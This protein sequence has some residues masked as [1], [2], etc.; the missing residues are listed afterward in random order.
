MHTKGFYLKGEKIMFFNKKENK[1]SILSCCKYPT[2]FG[3]KNEKPHIPHILAVDLAK[4]TPS[5]SDNEYIW[6]D[7]YKGT[8]PEMNCMNDFH[9]ELD[10]IYTI[11]DEKELTVCGHGFN[12]CLKLSDVFMYKP[13][14]FSDSNRYFK[15]SASVLKKDFEHYGYCS[16]DYN[17]TNKLVAKSIVLKEEVPIEEIY[18]NFNLVCDSTAIVN[19]YIKSFLISCENFSF[20]NFKY[21]VENKINCLDFLKA[22]FLKELSNFNFSESFKKVISK[23]YMDKN[24]LINYKNFINF[25]QSLFDEGLSADMRIYLIL[26]ELEK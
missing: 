18:K 26:K 9:Y 12:C 4:T 24:E 17:C 16:R 25:I 22:E 11:E 5:S 6:V 21:C 7:I 10:H 2:N 15:G 8:D 23:K 13:F 1:G 19:G 20:E 14:S 3:L